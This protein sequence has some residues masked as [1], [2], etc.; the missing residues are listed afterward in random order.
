[1]LGSE[2]GDDYKIIEEGLNGRTT[3]WDD[4]IEGYKNG[5]KYIVPCLASHAPLD[6]IIL[7][8]GTNDLKNRFSVSAYDIA[9]G[10]SVLLERI[11]TSKSA[12]SGK[13]P[14]I[15]LVCPPPVVRLSEFAD[16]FIGAEKKSQEFKKHYSRTAAE[17]QCAFINAGDFITS[18]SIDGIH[19][20]KSEHR[21]LGAV[22]A[23]KV[24]E[25]L[26]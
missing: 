11:E 23:D 25:I 3:V 24:K 20:E 19:L 22:L 6:L 26:Q 13:R 1:V 9:A 4:P 21:K 8:L 15:L 10:I 14:E 7:M 5:S 12:A 18:S 17:H 16:A 2:L